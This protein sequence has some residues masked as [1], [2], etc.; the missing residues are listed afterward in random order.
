MIDA[1]AVLVICVSWAVAS[2]DGSEAKADF[3]VLPFAP[4]GFCIIFYAV[5]ASTSYPR[6]SGVAKD[7][8]KELRAAAKVRGSLMHT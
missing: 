8:V 5:L 1:F 6:H 7:S 2:D 3:M 4:E